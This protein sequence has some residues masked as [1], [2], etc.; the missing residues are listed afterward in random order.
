MDHRSSSYYP[1]RAG[2][3]RSLYSAGYAVRRHLHLENLNLPKLAIEISGARILLCLLLPGFSFHDAGWKRWARIIAASW[4]AAGFVFLLWLGYSAANVAFGLMMSLHVSSVVHFLNRVAPGIS[5]WRRL[6]LSLGVLFVVG[7]LVYAT[8]LKWLQNQMFMPLQTADKV[9]VVNRLAPTETLRRGDWVAFHSERV[10]GGGIYIQEGYV[11]DRIL[12]GPGD[13]VEFTAADF[14]VNRVPRE[15]LPLMPS[16]ERLVLPQ[17]N[18]LIWPSL[19]T[20]TR[21]NI[22]EDA[23]ARSVLQMATVRREQIIG[24]PFRRWFWRDQTL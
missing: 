1:P 23:I 8:G 18:W 24:R 2:W 11:L 22:A 17:N 13:E 4:L 14:R 21:N 12:A 10:G 19:R 6:V 7:T 20:V 9:Y 3:N 5:V 15:K 16:N